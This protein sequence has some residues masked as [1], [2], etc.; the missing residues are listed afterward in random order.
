M[1]RYFNF[2]LSIGWLMVV[3]LCYFS[4]T[5]HPP[6][7]DIDFEYF[8]KVRHFIAYFV[9]MFWFAQLY[10]NN[11]NRMG[12]GI[13]FILMGVVLE[14]LQG[15][16]G[17]RYFE[18]YDMLANTVGVAIAWVITKKRWNTLFLSIENLF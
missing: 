7:F 6:E 18:Y 15:L 9:L 8:D 16:G 5:A 12:F 13:F 1:L 14:I 17:V 3:F 4:L 2:W 11:K 10:K